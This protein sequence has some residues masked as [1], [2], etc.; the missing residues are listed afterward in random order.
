[1]DVLVLLVYHGL[2]VFL[3]P[4]KINDDLLGDL[5]IS[6]QFASLLL[7]VQTA[8]LLPLVGVLQLVQSHLQ[9]L[10]DLVE[11]VHLLLGLVKLLARLGLTLL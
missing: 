3:V 7:H 10:F 4:L 1:M 8:F 9:L 2:E 5:Q 6:L 11:V